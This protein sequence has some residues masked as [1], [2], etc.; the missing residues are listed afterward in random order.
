[1]E[2]VT[3][4]VAFPAEVEGV[5]K[6]VIVVLVPTVLLIVLVEENS[7]IVYSLE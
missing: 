6:D 2:S 7:E 5:A 3:S 1:M 4:S